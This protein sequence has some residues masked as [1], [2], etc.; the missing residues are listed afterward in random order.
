M[1][2]V[3]LHPQIDPKLIPIASTPKPDHQKVQTNLPE[4]I[5]VMSHVILH[6]QIDPQL[7]QPQKQKGA[8]Q[9]PRVVIS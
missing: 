6:L 5:G 9:F 3:I 1:L 7:H 8:N 4:I 2:H